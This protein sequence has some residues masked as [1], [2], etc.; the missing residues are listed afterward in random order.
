MKY[1]E[2]HERPLRQPGQRRALNS[3]GSCTY[4]GILLAFYLE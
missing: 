2:T 4:L 3:R 1:L